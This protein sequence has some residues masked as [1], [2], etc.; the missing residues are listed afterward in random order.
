MNPETIKL[1][2]TLQRRHVKT[3]VALYVAGKDM[4]KEQR[5]LLVEYKQNNPQDYACIKEK[6]MQKL[7]R[8]EVVLGNVIRVCPGGKHAIYES[9]V[10]PVRKPHCV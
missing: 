4:T 8:M 7:A 1:L 5:V 3:L 9:N 2:A 6:A 10:G